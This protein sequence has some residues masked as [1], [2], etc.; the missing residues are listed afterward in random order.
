[1]KILVFVLIAAVLAGCIE[2]QVQGP[3]RIA[4]P[5][6]VTEADLRPFEF[7]S[8][9]PVVVDPEKFKGTGGDRY[10]C[11]EKEQSLILIDE[12][13]KAQQTIRR[14]QEAYQ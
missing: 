4:Y 7:S 11:I 2:K 13:S 12:M 8:F 9:E 3:E 14:L 1:V 10:F 6:S 5:K